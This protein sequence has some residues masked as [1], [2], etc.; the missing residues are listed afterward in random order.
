MSGDV[1]FNLRKYPCCLAHRGSFTTASRSGM[2]SGW[3]NS[4]L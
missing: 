4:I 2:V 3:L 1:A